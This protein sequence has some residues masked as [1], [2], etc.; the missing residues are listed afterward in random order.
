MYWVEK[1]KSRFNK[2]QN[3]F[4]LRTVEEIMEAKISFSIGKSLKY[5]HQ[6]QNVISD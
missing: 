1:L 6:Y 5:L 3:K 2:S 4:I